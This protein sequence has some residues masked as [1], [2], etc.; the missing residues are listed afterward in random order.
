ML[1]FSVPGAWG[2]YDLP[3][4][5]TSLPNTA[6]SIQECTNR[7]QQDCN[8]SI[9]FNEFS[10]LTG[11]AQ[12]ASNIHAVIRLQP[13]PDCMGLI[14]LCVDA[15]LV[16]AKEEKVDFL[17]GQGTFCTFGHETMFHQF[18]KYIS[19]MCNIFFQAMALNLDIVKVQYNEVAFHM[20]HDYKCHVLELAGYVPPTKWQD[21]LLIQT[22]LIDEG[23]L[24]PVG[25]CDANL[26]VNSHHAQFCEPAEAIHWVVYVLDAG[27][28]I[29]ILDSYDSY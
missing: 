25:C 18:G 19:D 5:S 17:T 23:C 27:E 15:I 7:V 1:A 11:E 16:T 21:S 12:N 6:C 9:V 20:L 10:V 22:Q 26:T 8:L 14:F 3:P 28:R 13:I 29:I 24:L 4:L 2:V